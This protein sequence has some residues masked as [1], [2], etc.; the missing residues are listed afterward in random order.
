[1]TQLIVN[2]IVH[3]CF[4]NSN[5]GD[6]FIALEMHKDSVKLK[7]PPAC[8]L[9]AVLDTVESLRLWLKKSRLF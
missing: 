4:K 8:S 2:L 3:S 1:M 7:K 5:N 9:Y 6:S